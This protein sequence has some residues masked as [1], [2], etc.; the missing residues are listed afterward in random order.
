MKFLVDNPLSPLVARRLA[1]AG[2]DS[3]H[4]RDYD[5]Q[6]AADPEIFDRAALEDRVLL[7]ADTDFGTL[8]ALRRERKPSVLLLRGALSHRPDDQAALILANLD[9]IDAALGAG[10][11][12]VI[13]PGRIR[14]RS[15]PIQGP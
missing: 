11:V 9:Q 15:L 12:V 2:H 13:E 3:V 5:L 4:V 14:V 7:S 8:L 1:D 10:A 6:A